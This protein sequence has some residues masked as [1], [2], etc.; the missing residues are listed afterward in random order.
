LCASVTT[1]N[2]LLLHAMAHS[3]SITHLHGVAFLRRWT[4]KEPQ[5]S[6]DPKGRP[7]SLSDKYRCQGKPRFL[8]SMIHKYTCTTSLLVLG[9]HNSHPLH[10]LQ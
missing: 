8:L 2:P 6:L 7:Q 10:L 3:L 9:L 1:W 5:L 4:E